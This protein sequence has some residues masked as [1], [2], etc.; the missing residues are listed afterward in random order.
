MEG[1]LDAIIGGECREMKAEEEEEL[2]LVFNRKGII[3]DKRLQLRDAF[4]EHSH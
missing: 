2:L 1:A 4:I 3:C